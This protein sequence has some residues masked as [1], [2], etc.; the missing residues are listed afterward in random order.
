MALYMGFASLL[1]FGIMLLS[2][3]AAWRR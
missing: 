3:I 1:A 2:K